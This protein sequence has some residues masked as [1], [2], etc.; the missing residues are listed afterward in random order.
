MND[1]RQFSEAPSRQAYLIVDVRAGDAG[2]D[3]LARALQQQH[4]ACVLLRRSQGLV[5][6]LAAAIDACQR[7]GAAALLEDDAKLALEVGA[8]GVHLAHAGDLASAE[9]RYREAR[10]MLGAGRIV[11]VS[12]GLLRHDA[13][14]LAELGADYVALEDV[15]GADPARLLEQVAWWGELFEVP[16][17]AW[18]ARSRAEAVLLAD[19]GADFVAADSLE[20]LA[21]L[22]E[23]QG[24]GA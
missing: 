13:M 24:A 10:A 5:R 22:T 3:Q 11:G 18:R 6:N 21:S 20:I 14:V 1:K 4:V 2:P 15:E 8:D 12:A 23:P 19:A 7:D 9:Q 16:C 17:V